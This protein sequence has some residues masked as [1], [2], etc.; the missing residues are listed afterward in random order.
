[1]NICT[2][3]LLFECICYMYSIQGFFWWELNNKKYEENVQQISKAQQIVHCLKDNVNFF[4]KI[5]KL[6]CDLNMYLNGVSTTTT[7]H[8]VLGSAVDD[9]CALYLLR[10]CYATQ[11]MHKYRY[12]FIYYEHAWLIA[13]VFK[14]NIMLIAAAR[15]NLFCCKSLQLS[16]MAGNIDDNSTLH[17]TQNKVS[18]FIWQIFRMRFCRNVCI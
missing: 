9:W 8:R 13:Y 16:I 12:F 6:Q 4:N 11:S 2:Y 3:N 15:Q 18:M 7:L 5:N 10:Q 17:N 14:R 1:M